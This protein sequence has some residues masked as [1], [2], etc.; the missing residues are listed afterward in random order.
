[1]DL[2]IKTSSKHQSKNQWLAE[3]SSNYIFLG[4][5]WRWYGWKELS[6]IPSNHHFLQSMVTQKIKFQLWADGWRFKKNFVKPT[7]NFNYLRNPSS[8]WFFV[9]SIVSILRRSM[10]KFNGRQFNRWIPWTLLKY[11]RPDLML[12]SSGYYADVTEIKQ[13]RNQL[14][15][16]IKCPFYGL[17]STAWLHVIL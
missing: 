10:V 8:D 15:S 13:H 6:K 5:S 7:R 4:K 9:P 3:I 14:F 17:R 16:W 11:F 1:M 2:V 12:Q